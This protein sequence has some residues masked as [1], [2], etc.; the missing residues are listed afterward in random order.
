MKKFLIVLLGLTLFL[1]VPLQTVAAV[2]QE[3]QEIKESYQTKIEGKLH[4]FNSVVKGSTQTI[5]ID[6]GEKVETI[7]TE[8]K[9][10]F[11]STMN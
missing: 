4:T 6:N 1:T 2:T 10:N 7:L 3:P 9:K 5:T 11:A 8:Q